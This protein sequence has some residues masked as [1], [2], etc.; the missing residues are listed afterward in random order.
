MKHSLLVL[1]ASL[2]YCLPTPAQQNRIVSPG[3]VEIRALHHLTSIGVEVKSDL[4]R[5]SSDDTGYAVGRRLKDAGV[6]SVGALDAFM[7]RLS[8]TLSHTGD[9]VLI[10]V[11]LLRLVSIDCDGNNFLMP[12]W[13]RERFSRASRTVNDLASLVDEFIDDYNS[14]NR[15]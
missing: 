2:L 8:V 6:P 9:V 5:I 15:R 1:I 14:I 10:R 7:G 4:R 11:R 3:Q 13:E 12:M